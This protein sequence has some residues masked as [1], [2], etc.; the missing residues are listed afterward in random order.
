VRGKTTQWR[1]IRNKREK[2]EREKRGKVQMGG[3]LGEETPSVFGRFSGVGVEGGCG[4][5]S[6]E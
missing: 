6:N 2:R 3:C 5:V 4:Y 1:G